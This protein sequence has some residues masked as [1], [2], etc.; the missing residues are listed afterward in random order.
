MKYWSQNEY[1]EMRFDIRPAL[2]DD[3]EGMRS[4]TNLWGQVYNSKQKVRTLLGRRSKGFVWFFSFLAWFSQHKK[5]K[6]PLIILLDEPSV[7]LHG[8]AQRDLLR[9]LEDESKFGNQVIYATQSPYMIDP[10][11]FERVR[12]VEDKSLTM[13]REDPS[14]V[15]TQVSTNILD[16]SKESILPLQGALASELFQSVYSGTNTLVVENL[17]DILYI[18]TVSRVLE[19][20]GR[21]GLNSRWSVVPVGDSGNL[22]ILISLM[23]IDRQRCIAGLMNVTSRDSDLLGDLE[24][25][26]I[27]QLENIF[28]ISTF[29]SAAEADIEDIFEADFYIGLVNAV[30]REQLRKGISK[31][32]LNNNIPRIV[33]RIE[34]YFSALPSASEARF[35]RYDPAVYFAGNITN[36]KEGLKGEPLDIFEKIFSTLNVLVKD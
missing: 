28:P 5:N 6:T 17:S 3:P 7:Y 26:K 18:N 33:S 15:G 21:E 32:R 19:A 30:Y 12:I 13:P 27:L 35:D 11:H 24:A 4:G 29:V 14:R 25:R 9:F 23:G 16:T 8:T 20:D 31:G 22:P 10:H 34:E 36:L 2:P 1:L